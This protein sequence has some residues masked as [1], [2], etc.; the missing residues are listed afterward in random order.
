LD[1][2]EIDFADKEG[3]AKDLKQRFS[4]PDGITDEDLVGTKRQKTVTKSD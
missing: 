2:K 3:N 1:P 4:L